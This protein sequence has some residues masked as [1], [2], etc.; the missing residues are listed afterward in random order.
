MPKT[1]NT[2]TGWAASPTTAFT[3]T[4]Q[5]GDT[6]TMPSSNVTLTAQWSVNSYALTVDLNSGTG[7]SG[8]TASGNIPYGSSVSLMTT[9]PTRAGYNFAGWKRLDTNAMVSTSFAMPAN[10]VTLQAQWSAQPVYTVTY[11]L[12]GGSGSVT[13]GD[14]YLAGS[15]VTIKEYS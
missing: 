2:F 5:S 13:D 1:G 15:T 10:A 8:G 6:F 4:K 12:N 9:A 11:D 3:G 7:G 14:S